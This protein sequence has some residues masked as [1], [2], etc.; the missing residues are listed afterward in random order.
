MKKVD[1]TAEIV[2]RY[3]ADFDQ[4]RF[5]LNRENEPVDKRKHWYRVSYPEFIKVFEDT[6]NLS[7]QD[8]WIPRLACIYSW[9]ARI[10]TPCFEEQ[11]FRELDGLEM[12][13]KKHKLWECGTDAWLGGL[14]TPEQVH[15]GEFIFQ[16]DK[17]YPAIIRHFLVAANKLLNN[18]NNWASN[19]PTVTK[20]LHFTFPNLFPIF[21]RNINKRIFGSHH[22]N[23][24]RYHGY[25]FGLKFFL[26][27]NPKLV[28]WLIGQNLN[29]VRV[30]E[31]TVFE[32]RNE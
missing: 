16:N 5:F 19:A 22:F 4:N 23:Y 6:Q 14:G 27:K 3:L 8:K 21:D 9:L 15:H 1:D 30:I 25:V 11:V 20:L 31:Q 7:G 10:P 17:G 28:N 13:Y 32:N 26:E 12:E 18:S 2:E 29:P 24:A